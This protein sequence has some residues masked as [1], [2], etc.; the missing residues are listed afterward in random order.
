MN[1]LK[2]TALIKLTLVLGAL[3]ASLWSSQGFASDAAK[4]EQGLIIL[5]SN[6]TQ[7]QGMAMVLGNTMAKQ[8]MQMNVLL[9][10]GAG[11]LALKNSESPVMKPKNVSPKM[12][13]KKL[14]KQGAKV[15]VCALYLPNSEHTQADLMVGV[16]VATPPPM[17]KMMAN[18][19]V[20]VFT[21]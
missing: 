21:F 11:D 10:D 6:S 9:C 12:L 15:S 8:G 4:V 17:A 19:A 20:R 2:L 7:T 5:S 14:K 13:L 16:D 1:K 18:P 3:C